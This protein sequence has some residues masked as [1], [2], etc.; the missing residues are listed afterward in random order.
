VSS[1]PAT[2]LAALGLGVFDFAG[3]NSV[4]DLVP[5]RALPS[6]LDL[7][8]WTSMK[9]EVRP[10]G[11]TGV[12]CLRRGRDSDRPALLNRQTSGPVSARAPARPVAG[13]VR[14]AA[15]AIGQPRRPSARRR[16]SSPRSIASERTGS[17]PGDRSARA[18][19]ASLLVF[20]VETALRTRRRLEVVLSRAPCALR[21]SFIA[22]STTFRRV[23]SRRLWSDRP[24][25]GGLDR[26]T[27]RA[28]SSHARVSRRRDRGARATRRRG[29]RR[30]PRSSRSCPSASTNRS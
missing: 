6:G 29:L 10:G 26:A 13:H 27:C 8:S 5:L 18:R 9:H 16:H 25:A 14:I 17:P 2:D 22:S 23:K 30:V 12:S 4:S 24:P 28:P 20:S 3:W 7:A 1:C 21:A 15:A 11:R 19:I